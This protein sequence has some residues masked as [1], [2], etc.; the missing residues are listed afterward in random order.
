MH[1][2]FSSLIREA[3]ERV[4]EAEM[5]CTG[6]ESRGIHRA[7]ALHV[8]F[9]QHL[10]TQWFHLGDRREKH[11]PGMQKYHTAIYFLLQDRRAGR[12]CKRL[13]FCWLSNRDK[14]NSCLSRL[15]CA[16][17]QLHDLNFQNWI[18]LC[19]SRDYPPTLF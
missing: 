2:E 12:L 4:S 9:L 3:R 8:G 17:T 19:V 5:R 1:K 13:D 15:G 18:R 16:G 10:Q 11:L 7:D 6:K 14:G